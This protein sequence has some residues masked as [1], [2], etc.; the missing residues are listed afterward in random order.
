MHKSDGGTMEKE[1]EK[2]LASLI[3]NLVCLGGIAAI[4]IIRPG[5]FKEAFERRELRLKARQNQVTERFGIFA[6]RVKTSLTVVPERKKGRPEKKFTMRELEGYK[7]YES[8]RGKFVPYNKIS[9]K[10]IFEVALK[11]LKLEVNAGETNAKKNLRRNFRIRY[12]KHSQS[13]KKVGSLNALR[14]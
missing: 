10:L 6:A 13:V 12:E 14:R 11:D 9:W 2:L 7:L 8:E 3:G 5:S 4:E 1:T